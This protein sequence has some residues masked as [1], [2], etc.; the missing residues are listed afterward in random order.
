MNRCSDVF[1]RTNLRCYIN[2]TELLNTKLIRHW[3]S[4]S[5][6]QETNTHGLDEVSSGLW[7]FCNFWGQ[8][9]NDFPVVAIGPY[10]LLLLKDVG[11]DLPRWSIPSRCA[12]NPTLSI[13]VEVTECISGLCNNELRWPIDVLSLYFYPL[14]HKRD[15]LLEWV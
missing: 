1:G 12:V 4:H 3:I 11:N 15:E 14:R 2:V 13:M 5:Q 9:N 8:R 7:K 10:I 6:V